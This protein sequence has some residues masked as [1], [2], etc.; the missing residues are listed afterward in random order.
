M[1]DQFSARTGIV[2][3]AIA[4]HPGITLGDLLSILPTYG[5]KISEKTL[6]KEIDKL[7]ND[8]GLL[9]PAPRLR[10]GYYLQGLHSLGLNELPTVID[11]LY[12]FGFNLSDAT[13]WD[14]SQR[15]GKTGRGIALRQ[16]NIYGKGKSQ[17]DVEEKIAIAIKEHKGAQIVI[18]TPHQEKSQKFDIFPLIKIFHERGWYLI[19]RNLDKEAF[20][21]SRIDRIKSI[22]LLRE[23]ENPNYEKNIGDAH[24]LMNSGWG[25]NFPHTLEDYEKIDSQPE[26]VV[27]FHASAAPFI[28]EG[29]ERHPRAKLEPAPDGNLNFRIRLYYYDEFRNWVRSWGCKAWFVEPESFVEA[30]RMEL[31]RQAQNYK[32][33][34]PD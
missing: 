29:V 12:A 17:E 9:S 15:L 22:Q 2:I 10:G 1:A 34:I 31:R 14:I 11:S 24:F 19:S 4:N 8:Y 20:F 27:R 5:L 23:H 33:S 18:E 13:A 25:M 21:A 30:E 3:R 28:K 16:K 7:K 26:V 6:T 32:M